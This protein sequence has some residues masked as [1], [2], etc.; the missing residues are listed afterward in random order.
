VAARPALIKPNLAEAEELLGRRLPTLD[1]AV[2]AAREIAQ[3][4]IDGVVISVGAR[5]AVG[6]HGDE[7]WLAT[8]PTI[9]RRSTVGSGDSLVAGLAVALARGED[10]AEGLKLGTAAG[11]ATAQT[12]RSS[13]S[14]HCSHESR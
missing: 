9:E 6:V 4:G 10:F 13:S 1:S 7:A 14:R 3:R 5:G 12:P 8:P 2:Q 11:A